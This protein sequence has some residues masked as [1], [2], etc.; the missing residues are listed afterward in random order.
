MSSPEC[1]LAMIAISAGSRS[2]ASIAAGLD[3]GDQRRTA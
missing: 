3:E 2:N 1:E